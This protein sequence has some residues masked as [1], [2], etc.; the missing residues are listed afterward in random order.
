MSRRLFNGTFHEVE[1][2]YWDKSQEVGR[3]EAETA[4]VTA[5]IVSTDVV[6]FTAQA[7]AWAL[8][9]TAMNAIVLG[10]PRLNR[11]VNTVVVNANPAKSAIDQS[12][13]REIKL[14]FLYIDNTTQQRYECTI[15]TL[16]LTKVVYLPLIGNDAVSLSSPTEMTN[17]ITAFQGVIVA[18]AT[19]N[20]V[21]IIAAEVVGRNN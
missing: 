2:S 3:F 17:L 15:P 14:K 12:A 4:V 21:T 13:V 16:N 10:L 11:W 5:T 8:L 9:V 18:P 1:I 19:G 7:D 20:P 6:N